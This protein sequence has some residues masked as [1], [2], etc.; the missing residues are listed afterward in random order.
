MSRYTVLPIDI[1]ALKDLR[2]VDDAGVPCVAY[3]ATDGD[4]GSPLRCCLRRIT[5]GERIALVS[6]AP[7]RRWA[8]AGGASPGAYDEQGPVF[9]HADDC[10]GFIP[11][12][13]YPFSRPGALRTVRRY[14]IRGRIAGGRLLEIPA[15]ATAGFDAAFDEA[16]DDPDVV[17][18]HVR[19]LEY[20]CFQFEVRRPAPIRGVMVLDED[21]ESS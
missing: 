3:N 11:G 15:D 8:V 20:G 10:G 17:L 19:A 9:I 6:Y 16:F 2:G 13:N 7:L 14:D 12:E 21:A 1:A 18:V 4:V 5:F